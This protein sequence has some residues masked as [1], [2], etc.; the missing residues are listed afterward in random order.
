MI[1][2]RH[3]LAHLI[4]G[5]LIQQD[6]S[7]LAWVCA[8]RSGDHFTNEA[9]AH[10]RERGFS[11]REDD[12]TRQRYKLAESTHPGKLMAVE[13]T[14]PRPKR[15]PPAKVREALKHAPKR[16]TRKAREQTGR[17]T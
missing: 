13:D 3:L 15:E 16:P 12:G 6:D 8:S 4:A 10:V 2:H 5:G 17:L 9:V 7:G 11:H 14:S 1:G